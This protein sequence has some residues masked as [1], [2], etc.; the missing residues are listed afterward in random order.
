MYLRK[1]LLLVVVMC[2]SPLALSADVEGE[3]CVNKE[4][5]KPECDYNGQI[6]TD[7]NPLTTGGQ[8][9]SDGTAVFDGS[10]NLDIGNGDIDTGTGTVTTT[11]LDDGTVTF[12]GGVLSDGTNKVTMDGRD[13][14][15]DLK[16]G[17]KALKLDV[18]RASILIY[19]TIRIYGNELRQT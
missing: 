11:T 12:S 19:F 3:I 4:N 15:L 5:G 14:S 7:G 17:T 10:G 1:V 16:N 6:L 13:A 2:F 9:L 18:T 8:E